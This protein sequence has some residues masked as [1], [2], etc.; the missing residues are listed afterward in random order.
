VHVLIERSSVYVARRSDGF[1][2]LRVVSRPFEIEGRTWEVLRHPSL[3]QDGKVLFFVIP[4]TMTT[5]KLMSYSIAPHRYQTIGDATNYC[6]IW[7]GLTPATK[8][9]N[10]DT[11]NRRKRKEFLTAAN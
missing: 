3:S 1:L 7:N 5:W 6:T 10:I 2:P 11:L 8:S 4:Y 9:Y